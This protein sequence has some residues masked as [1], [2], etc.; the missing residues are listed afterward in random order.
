MVVTIA[1]TM[2]RMPKKLPHFDDVG[3]ESPRKVKIN[4]TAASK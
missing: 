1:T 4:K 3:D 2:P